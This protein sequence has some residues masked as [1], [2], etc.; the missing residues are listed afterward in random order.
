MF[1]SSLFRRGEENRIFNNER[2][3]VELRCRTASRSAAAVHGD[4]D[5]ARAIHRSSSKIMAL[6]YASGGFE[7]FPAGICTFESRAAASIRHKT[8]FWNVPHSE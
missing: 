7:R 2:E 5:H 3:T 8:S 1:V 6:A 4:G